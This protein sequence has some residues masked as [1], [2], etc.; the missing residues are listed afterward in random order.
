VADIR[1]PKLNNNDQAYTLVEWLAPDSEP[2]NPGDTL[3]RGCAASA[4]PRR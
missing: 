4:G 2:A 3:A 1:V